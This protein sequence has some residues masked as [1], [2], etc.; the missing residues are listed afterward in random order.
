MGDSRACVGD[1]DDPM[2]SRLL[3]IG[4]DVLRSF[5]SAFGGE[6][7]AIVGGT[8]PALLVP[9]PPSGI[10]AH[11]GTSDLDLHLSLHLLDGETADYYDAII[12][13]LR[14]L[15]LRPAKERNREVG[16]RWVG[17]YRD[18]ELRVELLCPSRTR[19]GRPEAPAVGTAA[20]ENIGP[21]GEI[22][23]LA[24]GF[25]HVVPPDTVTIERRVETARGALTFE[26]PV[27]GLTS[28][29]CL[30]SD[31]IMRRDKPKDAYDVVWVVA[32]LG[33]DRAAAIIAESPLFHGEFAVEV[34]GQLRRLITDQ[35]RDTGSVGPASYAG[36]FDVTRDA[37]GLRRYAHGTLVALGKELGERGGPYVR[38]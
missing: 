31:A 12:D 22:T 23:A 6:H 19:S 27:A 1:Y 14:S 17:R 5:G 38:R 28:W 7:L 13:G 30:K 32:A 29:L 37:D 34:S 25:G 15:G 8:V 10:D 33:P 4:A 21:H 18:V 9:A 36:F 2:S 16:W 3:G 11:V 24:V 20:E 26:F 35:F